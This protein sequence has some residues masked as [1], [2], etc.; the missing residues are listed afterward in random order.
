MALPR[1]STPPF[2]PLPKQTRA[3]AGKGKR[4]KSRS[5]RKRRRKK[6]RKGKEKRKRVETLK[7]AHTSIITDFFYLTS[8]VRFSLF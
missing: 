4:K 3:G 6:K 1:V 7:N 5:G 2:A 8:S